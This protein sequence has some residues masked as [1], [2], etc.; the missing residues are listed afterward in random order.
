[1]PGQIDPLAFILNL[2]VILFALGIHEFAHAKLADAAGDPTPR[3]YGRVTLNLFNHLDPLGTLM[4]I[5]SS[6]SGVGIGWGR[7][8]PMDPRKM[9]DPRWDHFWAVAAGPLSNLIQACL[10]AVALRVLGAS[11]PLAAPFEVLNNASIDPLQTLLVSGV[12]VNLGLFCFNLIP[13][14]PL[15]GQWMLGS[16]LP[17]RSRDR[18]YLWNRKTG[19]FVLFGLLLLGWFTP[20][21]FIGMVMVPPLLLLFRFLVGG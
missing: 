10:F 16:F 2:F 12:L 6:L 3:I 20:F 5:M 1:M 7:P 11:V 15:D 18:W 8:V 14:G 13:L 4:I 19:T 21:S 9:R 17:E